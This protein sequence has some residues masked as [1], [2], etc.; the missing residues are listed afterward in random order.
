ML[1]YLKNIYLRNKNIFYSIIGVIVLIIYL[2]VFNDINKK[3]RLNTFKTGVY[4][5]AK[6]IK[7]K[8]EARRTYY[9]YE[10]QYHNLRYESTILH[11]G[12]NLDVGTNYFLIIDPKKPDYNNFLLKP[13]S[14]PDSIT[15][16]PS[17][18]WEELPIPIDKKEIRRFL[19]EY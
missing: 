13:F 5:I 17:A 15:E 6:V 10:F 14:V 18:G 3:R 7:L 4:T 12:Y 9:V 19:E 2:I 8:K 11:K 16:S 1:L